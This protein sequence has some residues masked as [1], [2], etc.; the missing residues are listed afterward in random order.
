MATHDGRNRTGRQSQNA[1]G[2]RLVVV[3]AEFENAPQ[4]EYLVCASTSSTK[5]GLVGSRLRV[6]HSLESP[7]LDNSEDPRSNG[8]EAYA[9][10]VLSSCL[11]SLLEDS[12]PTPQAARV[13]SPMLAVWNVRSPLDNP[14]SNRPERKAALVSRELVRYKA[15]IA[16]LSET[17][18]SEQ[19]QLVD[20]VAGYNFFWSGRLRA[21]RRYAGVPFA[22]RDDIVGRQPCL[23]Q[24]IDD[25]LMSLHL[26]LREGKFAAIISA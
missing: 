10:V 16:A 13:S 7:E 1:G 3:M 9:A 12:R 26:P 25:R 6:T 2:R 15:D 24:G 18:L 8:D 20:V 4:F 23:S 19:G 17:R 11:I 21:E 5:S 14:R 22:I